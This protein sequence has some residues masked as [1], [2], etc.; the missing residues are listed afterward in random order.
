LVLNVFVFFPIWIAFLTKIVFLLSSCLLIHQYHV[1]NQRL[2]WIEAQTYCRHKYTDQA[3]I[4]NSEEMDQLI[5]TITGSYSNLWI[6][7]YNEIN[8][9]WSDGFIGGF[10]REPYWTLFES[11]CS[12]L[13]SFTI[14]LFIFG[15]FQ[16]DA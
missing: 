13:L 15:E 3:T 1:F 11:S 7:L 5:N 2:N 16:S 14:H 12:S 8:W 9:R 4:E 6:G 10:T